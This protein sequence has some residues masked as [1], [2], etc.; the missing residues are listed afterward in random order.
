MTKEYKM[1]PQETSHL[2]VETNGEEVTI[3]YRPVPAAAETP[4]VWRV[5][6]T[7][8]SEPYETLGLDIQGELMLGRDIDQ[9]NVIDLSACG[10]AEHGVS[11][12]HAILRPTATNLFL[13]DQGSTNGT[14]RNGRS[15]GVKTPYPIV[16]GDVIGLGGLRLAVQIVERPSLQRQ[17]A[18]LETTPDLADAL[19]QI[20]KSIT[21]QLHVDEVL[22]QVAE[23]AML[24]TAAGETGIWLVDELTGEMFL[25][26][27]RG[28]Q[29]AR[30]RRTRLPIR[31]D[32]LAGQVIQ[33]GRP[34][35]TSRKEDGDPIKVKTNYLVEALVYV[36][37]KLGGVTLGVMSAVHRQPGKQFDRRDER[38]LEAI[39]DFAAIAIQNARLYQATDKAL[40]R[41]VKELTALNELSHTVSASLDLEEVYKV[42]VEQVNKNWQI[43]SLSLYLLNEDQDTLQPIADKNNGEE[44]VAHSASSQN[45]L[46]KA[47]EQRRPIVA[48]DMDEEEDSAE[49]T[50]RLLGDHNNSIA[51][52]PLL[53]QDE[54]VGVLALF[55]KL[56]GDFTQEDVERLQAFANPMA[57]AI[58]NARL[59]AQA[60]QRRRAVQATAQTI[61]QPLLILDD[62]GRP[63]VANEAAERLLDEHMSPLF[64]GISRGVGRTIE[65]EI[66][67]STYLSTA[68]HLPDVG[69]I[70]VMQ[71][72][73][74][75]KK[76]EQDRAEILHTISHDLKSPLTSISG[77]AQLLER[78]MAL[79]EKAA[80][81]LRQIIT[82]SER[83]LTMINQLLKVAKGDL[84]ELER[85]PCRLDSVVAQAIRDV[86]GSALHKRIKVIQTASGQP[87]D[88]LGDRERLYHLVLNLVDNAIKY[89][90]TETAV[91]VNTHYNNDN[92]TLTVADE[93]PGIPKEDLPRIF[94][95]YYRGIAVKHKP[96]AGLGLSLVM[97]IVEAHG[98]R[99]SVQNNSNGGVTF[100]VVLPVNGATNEATSGATNGATS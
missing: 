74:Y 58:K 73:T 22:N 68:Q 48:N 33:S 98:G 20:A 90:P 63:V 75:V 47:V 14:S 40:A 54:A 23:T 70:V 19:S 29:D 89:S 67:E 36:P 96:G 4:F 8:L 24:L 81:Y 99:V 56:D 95:K 55:N 26:A 52:V 65:I 93:G 91:S 49:S 5:R 64:E 71:D 1:S 50:D 100:T 17:T 34:L 10:A 2:Q 13:I 59:F 32:T 84:I 28:I 72:I 76:L 6:F 53:V 61:S 11:R 9:D 39:A 25:E 38:L 57:T 97:A 66:G 94:D 31:E 18:Q 79:D 43:E 42:L 41:R 7:A 51:C 3:I 62:S 87:V 37:I 92:I 46:W 86:E 15:I 69:T 27:E 21:S 12:H 80:H 35:R 83:L 45:L 16:T 30:L 85:A 77:Y 60:E 82:A 78:I 44:G 88:I